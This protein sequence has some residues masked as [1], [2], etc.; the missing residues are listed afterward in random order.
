MDHVKFDIWSVLILFGA[1]LGIY[2]SLMLLLKKDNKGANRIFAF[3]VLIFT[4][5]LIE[6][7]L[8]VTGLIRI[9]PHLGKT[10]YPFLFLMG[11]LLLFH[12]QAL[13]GNSQFH[14]RKVLHLVP[15]VAILIWMVPYYMLDASVKLREMDPEPWGSEVTFQLQNY[16]VGAF[17]YLYNI[18]YI[19]LSYRNLNNLIKTNSLSRKKQLRLKWFNKVIVSYALFICSCLIFYFVAALKGGYP[20]YYDYIHLLLMALMI[21]V[22][23]Y[24]AINQPVLFMDQLTVTNQSKYNKSR[25][26]QP[27]LE[28]YVRDLNEYF[29]RQ[30]PF[31]QEG[32]TLDQ[33]SKGCGL[34][35]HHVSLV[36]N[37]ELGVSFYDFVNKH[38]VEEAKELFKQNKKS[39][40]AMDIGYQAGFGNKVSFHRAFKKFE[41]MSP[42]EFR[43]NHINTVE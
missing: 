3:I 14:W 29:S 36:L 28:R 18:T 4:F 5:H 24:F 2:L 16:T 15:A 43:D 7:A 31:L 12:V 26:P 34:S 27:L 39:S 17:F 40:S 19:I 23:G 1:L 38:R 33:V 25:I 20:L 32:L 9:F 13:K 41:G 21:N 6:T 10:S 11:P 35:K 8:W 42:S 22:V 30:K 37:Q